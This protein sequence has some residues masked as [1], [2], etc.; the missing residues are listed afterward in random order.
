[1]KEKSSPKSKGPKTESTDVKTGAEEK[2]PAGKSA[3]VKSK[4]MTAAEK[5]SKKRK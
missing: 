4:E 5:K 3:P 2:T 1:M